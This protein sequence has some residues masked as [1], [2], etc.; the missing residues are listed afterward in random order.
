MET[1][2]RDFIM[3]HPL[4][5]HHDHHCTFEEFEK[6]REICTHRSL[7]GYA[8]A[9]LTTAA[10][11]RPARYADED[12]RM[13]AL[14]PYIRT[15]GY[16]RAVMSGCRALFGIEYEPANFARITEALRASVAGRT[17]AEAYD[18]FVREKAG[19]RWVLLDWL[20][21]I[22]KA[23]ALRVDL[24]PGYYRF[25][26]RCDDL[27]AIEN[28]GP[29]EA[30][31]RFTGISALNLDRLVAALNAA[32]EKFKGTG[33]LAAFKVGIAYR[34]D[35][36][37]TDP[38]RHEAERAFERIRNGKAFYSGMQQNGAAVNRRESRALSDYLLR[39][40]IE[41][42]DDEDIPVQFHTGYLAGHWGSLAGTRA[43]LLIPLF[44]RYRR[45]RFDVFHGSWPWM[46]E[47]GAIAKNYPN[48]Y[49]DLCWA[50]AMNP[51]ETERALCEWLDAIPFNKIFAFGAD[52]G[53]PWCEAGYAVQA[54]E[55]IARALENKVRKGFFSGATAREVAS[56]I[57]IG[58]GER[59]Y[60]I[61]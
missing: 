25:A 6:Q 27:F 34:R 2:I 61:A 1:G 37:V 22:E 36:T 12:A 44:D 60:G 5:S 15:T 21:R 41:R 57:M 23:E 50:W 39:R 49:P 55:G 59:F 30:I 35:L 40:L 11:P 33:R 7:L 26:F 17:P 53:F 29:I 38:T 42:A 56:A 20:F 10:G 51:E 47:L 45:V 14:W 54:R 13:E 48:V 43:S 19:V 58:N 28:A 4:F 16:G 52:T 24:Y 18:W 8:G 46:S 9:D 32:I 31:E 3:A